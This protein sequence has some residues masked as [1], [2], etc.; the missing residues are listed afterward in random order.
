MQCTG[1]VT[2]NQEVR[3]FL[4]VPES[5]SCTQVIQTNT[6]NPEKN[7]HSTANPEIQET[8]SDKKPSILCLGCRED[9]NKDV[10]GL[11]K[12]I[13]NALEHI[14]SEKDNLHRVS[15]ILK[16][17]RQIQG[18]VV[19]ILTLQVSPTGCSKDANRNLCSVDQSA[20]PKI[21]EIKF[22]QRPWISKQKTIFSNNCTVSQ[23]FTPV[24]EPEE[25]TKKNEDNIVNLVDLESQIMPVEETTFKPKWRKTLDRV[26]NTYAANFMAPKYYFYR[27][28]SSPQPSDSNQQQNDDLIHLSFTPSYAQQESVQESTDDAHGNRD[29][30]DTHKIRFTF[31]HDSSSSSS[32]SSDDDDDLVVRKSKKDDDSDNSSSSSSSDDSDDKNKRHNNDDD[33]SSSSSS[34]DDDDNHV[35]G[36]KSSKKTDDDSS[37]SSSDDDDDNNVTNNDDD[38]SSS[39]SDDSAHAKKS[40]NRNNKDDDSSSSSSDDDDDDNNTKDDDDDS[41]SSSS[42]DDDDSNDIIRKPKKSK[43]N[44]NDDNDDDS[45]SSSSDDDDDDK[46]DNDDSSSSSSSDDDDTHEVKKSKKSKNNKNDDDSSSSSSDDD[47]DNKDDDDDSSSSS[48][49]DDDNTLEVKK[50]KKSNKNKKGDDDD[51][52][53]SSSSSDDDD[54]NEVIKSKKNNKKEDDISSSSD[55]DDHDDD[56]D[57]SSS[58]SSDD[59]DNTKEV[60]KSKKSKNNEKDDDDSSSSSDDDDDDDDDDES[61][62][63]SSDDD[64]NTKEAKKSKK[65]KNNKND[66]DDSSSS[67]DDDDTKEVNKSKKSKNNKSDDDN[68]SSS[69]SSDDDD[70]KS[71]AKDDDDSNSSSSDDD[72]TKEVKKSNKNKNKNDDDSSSS[73]SDDD[74]DNNTKDDND[75]SS[76]SSSDDD[77]NGKNAKK[78]NKKNDDDDS[79]SSSSDEDDDDDDDDDD[80]SS[81]SSDD[82]DSANDVKNN[83]KSSKKKNSNNKKNADDDDDSSSSSSD[84]DDNEID[85]NDNK[86][87]KN[88]KETDDDSSSSSD[89]DKKNNDKEDDSSS[90]SSD[91]DDDND[92]KESTK[93]KTKK[94][95]D[96]D[97]NSKSKTKLDEKQK[98]DATKKSEKAKK[99]V[100]DN[101]NNDD[102]PNVRHMI[103]ERRNKVIIKRAIPEENPLEDITDEDKKVVHNIAKTAASQMDDEHSHVVKHILEAKKIQLEGTVYYLTI[104]VAIEHCP[105][106]HRCI[107]KDTNKCK[108]QA[109]VSKEG[110]IK[111]VNL[112]CEKSRKPRHLAGGIKAVST[113][114][115]RVQQLMK[116]TLVQLDQ[117]SSHD[118][119]YKTV[120]VISASRQVVAGS[121]TRIKVK[122]VLSDCKKNDVKETE[123]CGQLEGAEAKECNIKVWEQPWMKFKETNVTCDEESHS[124]RAKRSVKFHHLPHLMGK[125]G[126]DVEE[127]MFNEFIEKYKKTYEGGEYK[128]RFNIFRDNMKKVRLLNKHE[129]GTGKYGVTQFADLSP[130]EFSVYLGYKSELRN[131]NLK[132]MPMAKIPDVEL[133]PQFDWRQKGVVSEVKNQGQ[134]GSCWA[135][136]VTGN[137][138]GQYALKYGKLLEFSEQELVDCDK[139]DSGCNGG[140]MDNAYR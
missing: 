34:S 13:D 55:D 135:F 117:K 62:S 98:N 22:Y 77:N 36:K 15:S 42:D 123:K 83:N 18:G 24:V 136:S 79:S 56:D 68:D 25:V 102:I 52:D 120:E 118:N 27:E 71:N 75:D 130:E 61:S 93:D 80:S 32:S 133:D 1:L 44:K 64:D 106:E 14:E 85:S 87:S 12:L 81:S 69:S 37:S 65:S 97:I 99:A 90:S 35:K 86:K 107:E 49:D 72:D 33:S 63:S 3:W 67:S 92:L 59:D 20:E 113:T 58:S 60:K 140:L 46:K 138:E 119:K 53:S 9:V 26:Y 121:L 39:S 89:D 2:Y 137:V 74:D 54:T 11:D 124:F 122:I 28:T 115:D 139:T 70:E 31:D 57:E 94:E 88:K 132:K 129:Q 95:N 43:N 103:P 8:A 41:S 21:C 47:D 96:K 101:E 4:A 110:T 105:H 17:Q 114:D 30:R 131:P 84:D 7:V 91:D 76:S 40:K 29:K 5:V 108:V 38:D 112:E 128:R 10:K 125:H 78:S 51:D 23:D 127:S 134:C 82:D 104:K 66:D 126:I 19:Y 50:S 6:E 48:N 100:R 45:S 73:S 109:H 116:E 16:V 111:I